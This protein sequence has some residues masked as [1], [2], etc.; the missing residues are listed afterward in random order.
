M[1]IIGSMLT[2]FLLLVGCTS[3]RQRTHDHTA[4]TESAHQ[5]VDNGDTYTCPMHPNVV[6]DEPGTCPL[7]GMDLVR[8]TRTA[9]DDHHIMLT[10][11]QLRLA[12]VDIAPVSWQS[13]G[14]TT[15][16]NAILTVDEQQS[17]VISSRSA[18][19][20]ER[21]FIKETGR[22][23]RQGKPLYTLYSEEL[24]TLQQE[25][26]LAKEQYEV[27]EQ[28]EP[29]YKS[30]LD[31]ARRKLILIGLTPT[32]IE[33]LNKSNVKPEVMFMAPQSGTV[34]EV[35]VAEGA[36]VAE[37][38][39]LFRIEDTRSLWVEAELY[40]GEDA[41]VQPGDSITI[42]TEGQANTTKATV[43]FLSPEFRRGTQVSI[44]RA[45]IN[46][47]D[48]SLRPGQFAQVHLTHATHRALAVPLDA[49]I[50]DEHGARVYLASGKHAF[51]PQAVKTGME[52]PDV[53]EITEGLIEGDT[54]AVTGAY[55][56]YSEFVL[57][58]GG[59]PMAGH[60]H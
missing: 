28:T 29:R 31:A 6:Q 30:F 51:R 39:P 13:V 23:V 11:T 19:R 35:N 42:T 8:V 27:L 12:N 60:S 55:L 4:H 58:Q 16:V 48:G 26:L 5:G 24:L 10:D 15:V 49:V 21:I 47:P 40:P 2:C 45:R 43:I 41:L 38:T 3:D 44:L 14:Q 20:I 33:R 32:Q 37:G 56:L 59:D 46:N 34:Y 50:R 18:G 22:V 7:C 36:Y 25:Y 9:D 1:K 57:K 17:G 52:G 54:I 53:I